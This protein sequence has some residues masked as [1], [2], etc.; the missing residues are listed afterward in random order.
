MIFFRFFMIFFFHN[1]T[2]IDARR[3]RGDKGRGRCPLTFSPAGATGPRCQG[4]LHPLL[5]QAVS[6]LP[7]LL[8]GVHGVGLE[9]QPSYQRPGCGRPRYPSV[10]SRDHLPLCQGTHHSIIDSGHPVV[11]HRNSV[12]SYRRLEPCTSTLGSTEGGKNAQRQ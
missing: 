8:Y 7:G 12:V 9:I 11:S 3:L 1:H 10:R 6:L 4:G 5:A 2:H